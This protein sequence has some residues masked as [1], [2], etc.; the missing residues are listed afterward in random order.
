MDEETRAR[1]EDVKKNWKRAI[2]K[3]EYLLFLEGKKL[4]RRQ[5][6]QAM[7]YECTAGYYDGV[8]DCELRDKPCYA[9]MPYKNKK[10]D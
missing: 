2:G 4:S 10:R 1:Y 7:C 6:M 9:F 5:I 8:A 3:Q